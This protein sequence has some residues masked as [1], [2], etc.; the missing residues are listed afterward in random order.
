MRLCNAGMKLKMLGHLVYRQPSICLKEEKQY[1]FAF[2]V[3]PILLWGKVLKL[4]LKIAYLQFKNLILRNRL[5]K[6]ILEK[7]FISKVLS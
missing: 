3:E 4:F 1:L 5:R 6:A 2:L 7:G